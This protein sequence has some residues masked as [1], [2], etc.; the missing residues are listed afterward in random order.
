[1]PDIKQTIEFNVQG[2]SE[3]HEAAESINTIAQALDN[4]KGK[5]VGA[6]IGKGLDGAGRGGR[7]AGEGFDRAGRAAEEAKSRISNMR[8]ALYDV[9]A[10]MQSISKH[11]IGAFTTVVKESMEY[12]S[13]FAQV[14]RTND[15]AGKSADELRGKL[16]QMASSVTTTNFKDLSNIAAL[17][18]QLGV[19]KESITDFTETVAKLSATTDLSLDKSGETIARFQTIMGTT[20]Q[21]FDNIASSILKVGVNSAATE[22][23]IANTSTQISAMGK[24]AGM[25][26]YQ[27]VGLSGA[28]A[29]I[30]VAP[31]LSR[32]VIT[33]MFTQMQ[34]AI[35][36]GGDELNLFARV[37]GV[38]AQEVQSA[39][40]TSKFSDIF[41]KFIAGLKNQGQGAIGVLKDL[42]IKASRDVPT[43][44]RLAEAHKTL[45]QTMK[46]AEA[47]YNDSK[48]LNDQYQQIASTTAGKLEMLKNSWANLKAEIGR[49]TNSGIGDMLGSLTGLVTVLTNLV[50]N[51]AAQWVAK[52]AG[53]FLTAGGIMAGYYAKQAL[54]LGGAYALTTAQRSMGIAMQ[55]P[56]TS[57]RSLLSAL[58]ETVKLYKLSTVSVNEQ[59]GAL[60]KNAGAARGAAA[61]QRAAGQAA[62]SQSA[63]GAAAGGAGQAAGAM[64]TAEKAT[65]GLMGALKGLAAGAGIS[66]FFTGLAKVTEGWTK[67]SEAAR[68]EAKAL[69]QAQAD[70]AQ[71]V[72]QDTKAFEEG[73]S[74]AY[75][76]AK[77]TNKA[78]ESMSSQ[79]FSTSDANAQTK[80]LAQA[81]ELLA[82][83]TGQSTDEIS[84]QTYAIGENSLKK[85]AEQIAGNTGFKQ[86]GDEQLATLRQMGFSVQ[87]YSKLVTQGNSEMTD[88]QKKLAELYRQNGFGSI[89]DD[90]ERSTQKSSQYIDSFKNKIQ[91]MV[92]SGK[93]SWFDGE[94]ILDTL[95]KIDDNAHQ[96]FDGVRNESDL[97]AQTMK[98]LKGDTADAAD[99]MDNMGEKADKA[100]KELKKV[101]DS[102]LSGD[103]AFVN[104][105]DAVAN[106]GESLYKNGMN[107]DEF[108]EAGRSNLKALYAVVRQAAE[109][110]GGDAEVMNAYIQQIM[111]LLRSHGVGSV[112]VLERVEQRLHAV[113]NKA[114][115]S[116]NQIAK[117]A[118]LAQKA[119]NAI[120]MIAASIATGKDFSKEASASL[121]G[122]GKS[123][124]AALPSIKDLGKA[125]DQGFARG[126]R[127]AAKH[128]KKARHRTRKL[129]D[130]AK[131]AGKKIKE[132]AKEIKTFTDYISELSSVAN[133][134][135]NFRWEFPK[136]LDETAKSFKTIKSY[137]ENAAKDA[138]SANKEI[139][140]ANK[141]IEETRNKIAELDAELSKLQS[142]RNKLT[143][144]LKV[145]VD[146]GDTLRADD[147]RA[148]LQKNAAAQ[149]K[150]RTDRKNAE[151]DQAGNYQKL[152]EAMQKLSDAQQKARRDLTGFSDAAREQ[153]GNVLSL[154]E[155]YQKQVLAYANTGASQQQVLAYAS[156][157]RAEF[158]NNMTSMGYSRAET[159]RYAATFTDL[160]K[161]INGVPRN[162]TVG[163][164]ADPALRA[165]SDLEAKNRKSQH[166]MDDNRDAADKLGNSL[167]NTGGDAA[168]L[169]GALGGGGVG[170]AAE[171]AAVTF[172]QLG[173]ITGNIGA[174]MWKAAGSANTAAHGLGNMGNQ[175]HGSAYS[176]DVAG[177][178]AGWMSYAINGIREAGYGAF[179][180]I[181]SSAQQAGF[182]F[183]QAATDAINLCNRVR[184]LRSLSVGQFMFG[185]NQAWG[186]STGGKV[187]GSSYSGGKQSTDTVPA[188]LTPGE[189]VINR[190][191]A[192]T[193]GYGFLEAVNS[194]RAAASGASAAS[195]G[196]AGGGFGGG[197][198]LVELS[199]TDRH[200]LVSAVNKPTVIDGNAIVGMVNGSNAL[201]SRRGA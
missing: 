100:A 30:G 154:V 23:Q 6:D 14:K 9:A 88:S 11:T 98:G 107:F 79:L 94:K 127:N 185:F 192:Q 145:A 161:V 103:E 171:Q 38:S 12:E 134:A 54:V 114:T 33:R 46:D 55:H 197:P 133:A 70:L 170:G 91:E 52:L 2:T 48:T 151:G 157:L 184:D 75:V 195:S 101:V 181:I 34:K 135:F 174:E 102:A 131:K 44:L 31:E 19:A 16:E 18:G 35:R 89:A 106:L 180:N 168:G 183:N 25:T 15:I 158:I 113:A 50:Q 93:I 76:F 66:L 43:I 160:S 129:G 108:S 178:K 137:F 146:Y 104:L 82:Q 45:E 95:K 60:Y 41:V 159:E 24:F 179:S 28:L 138:Q 121:Q 42:G 36:G 80:A 166:S 110:S 155:A 51:P 172:Q 189:F 186:F 193:V 140:D 191:A 47:G 71:S 152:Y 22:S 118:V 176:M 194:G 73:G 69:Q 198:I 59:T 153:R 62:A 27:V 136:S 130:R 97:A 124:T 39:W 122:L 1:M 117:A 128:A 65:S 10:V 67:R 32:G 58:A 56:I 163:V 105:E 187:G 109:A 115:Q 90:I 87:E 111:Q 182:S 143:F 132:A 77:A 81:Q 139:G 84:K 86:F 148:E 162:F 177:N 13:A 64:G 175:A 26:E 29:S 123:S 119:G 144:Q 85:M 37:A 164:N 57:I 150:N 141:S 116:A 4:I 74:A 169:G 61:S 201:A 92:A 188:M 167:N 7:E 21:N 126:A 199:G 5:V 147:I 125:L 3:L 200:I 112:Q 96:T 190:Q 63:A 68:A 173:Q 8:Y 40:G 72:M 20:G 78:G 142:D 156:A 165:L 120:G 83:K 99:E 17:G 53:A 196:G 49:S 149:Q